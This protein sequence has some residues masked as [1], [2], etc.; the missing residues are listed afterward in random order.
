M[1]PTFSPNSERNYVTACTYRNWSIA[2]PKRE[3]RHTVVYYRHM[4]SS[5]GLRQ[6]CRQIARGIG[7]INA[8]QNGASARCWG[9]RANENRCWE[10]SAISHTH[11]LFS[12]YYDTLRPEEAR[13]EMLEANSAGLRLSSGDLRPSGRTRHCLPPPLFRCA[14]LV[15]TVTTQSR[16]R[17]RR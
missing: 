8:R 13:R 16:R 5:G 14:P 10:R 17:R 3:E 1:P 7:K 6:N 11:A 4:I 2:R 12:L 15:R 9:M